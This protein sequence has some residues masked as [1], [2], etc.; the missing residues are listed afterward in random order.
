MRH[1]VAVHWEWAGR[2]RYTL[3]GPAAE[4]AEPSQVMLTPSGWGHPA[5][6]GVFTLL[7][8]FEIGI[9]L[10]LYRL[11][12][13]FGERWRWNVFDVVLI[14]V[15][16]VHWFINV[17]LIDACG[18]S[19]PRLP[20]VTFLRI[21]RLPRVAIDL[22]HLDCIHTLEL[23]TASIL[24]SL[25]F[26]WVAF[27][28]VIC[29]IYLFSVM[30]VQGMIDCLESRAVGSIGSGDLGQIAEMFGSVQITLMS[31]FQAISGGLDWIE[32]LGPLSLTPWRYTLLLFAYIFVVTFGVLNIVTSMFV[33]CVCQVTK[34]NYKER[35]RAE[36]LA[37]RKWMDQLR[38]L[39]T[40]ADEDESGGLSWNEFSSLVNMPL[41]RAYFKTL[42]LNIEEAQEIFEYLDVK[43]EGEVT[44]QDFVNGFVLLRGEAKSVDIAVLRSQFQRTSRQLLDHMRTSKRDIELLQKHLGSRDA[45]ADPETTNPGHCSIERHAT[46]CSRSSSSSES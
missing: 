34:E 32:L 29:I 38:T 20:R 27:S 25:T 30:F 23:M 39:F 15:T 16:I 31:L 36:L 3:H 26:S 17:L 40:E 19:F 35:I 28:V 14:C 42:E 21:L 44:L 41:M 9:R 2:P 7:F 33:E 11:E 45:H 1:G 4:D 22:S 12:F 5:L 18:V 43:G 6:D 24:H 46:Y 10:W 13:F 37:Q 8:I